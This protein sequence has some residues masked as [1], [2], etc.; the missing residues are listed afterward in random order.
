MV[1]KEC[2][3]YIGKHE[4]SRCPLENARY[5]ECRKLEKALLEIQIAIW[6][7]ILGIFKRNKK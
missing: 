2:I 1:N 7:S 4:G 5:M 3:K 6:K